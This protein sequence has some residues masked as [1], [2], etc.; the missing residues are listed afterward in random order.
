MNRHYLAS[1]FA[2]ASVA[3]F[4]ASDRQD[5]V[6]G[7][8]LRNLLT[9]DYPGRVYPINPRREE[10]QGHKAYAS[11]ADID[12]SVDLAVVATPADSVLSIVDS[13]GEHGVRMMLVLS[14][15]FREVGPEGLKLEQQVT[16]SAKRHGIRLMGPNSLGIIRPDQGLNITFGHNNAQRGNL[17]LVSQSGAL[18]TAILDWAKPRGIGFSSVVSTGIAAD[19]DFVMGIWAAFLKKMLAIL[20]EMKR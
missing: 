4:G 15:G 11:L 7:I 19:L 3:L 12:D 6:G 9:S 20:R 16:Q 18:C 10:V 5:S 2:P 1:L 17:A 14:A 13:C 8:V